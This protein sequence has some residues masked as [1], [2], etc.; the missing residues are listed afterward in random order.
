MVFFQGG[1]DGR[2]YR[3]MYKIT[4]KADLGSMNT[5]LKYSCIVSKSHV[6]YETAPVGE[7]C[8]LQVGK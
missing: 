6:A 2:G 5:A 7:H 1:G 3:N 4:W 8:Y